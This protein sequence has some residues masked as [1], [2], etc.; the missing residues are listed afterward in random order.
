MIV[1]RILKKFQQILN[2]HQKI[3]IIELTILMVI[4]GFMEMLSVSL[5]VPFI[6]AVMDPGA[7]MEKWYA[8]IFCNIF[9]IGQGETRKF[10]IVLAVVLALLYVIKNLYL[11]LE[12]NFQYRFVY[13]NMF[14]I[15]QRLLNNYLHRPYEYFLAIETGEVIRVI[16]TDVTNS[17]LA[18]TSLL[19]IFAEV[20]VT[21]VLLV[22]LLVISTFITIGIIVILCAAL[23]IIMCV[24]KPIMAKAGK[25]NQRAAA[26][27]NKWMMQSIQGIKEIKISQK[28]SYFEKEFAANGQSYVNTLRINAVLSQLPRF[29]IE[30]VS[31]SA[32][33]IMIAV[34]IGNGTDLVTFIPTLSALAMAAVR[35]L[36][37][38]NRISSGLGLLAYYEPSIDKLIKNLNEAQLAPLDI[39]D[40]RVAIKPLQ[41]N[42]SLSH[43]YF[44]YPSNDDKYVLKDSSLII[45][46]GESI[47]ITGPSGAGKTTAIDI[48]IGLLKPQKGVV[49]ID[50]TDI[51][52]DR[53]DWFK[54]IGYI[55]QSIFML[56]GSIRDNVAFGILKEE[57]VDDQIWTALK[58]ASL[59]D[60]VKSLPDQL[61]TKVGE[62]GVRISGGQKQRIGI[63][64][65]LYNNPSILIFDEATSALD[66]DTEKA[67]M[68][69]VE[70]LHGQ[71]TMVIIAHRLTTIENCDH[72]FQVKDSNIIRIR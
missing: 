48:L 72:V 65:A 40:K 41:D 45:H 10:L 71:K 47:G 61:D 22:T 57:V 54:Q 18:L 43:I 27:I 68:Q 12:N 39:Y 9:H 20:I 69:S 55:P 3:R 17:F 38:I 21:G 7:T 46:K 31:M 11:L 53:E 23:L 6:N 49:T 59:Y 14:M 44:H 16:Q 52:L 67:I 62:R 19:E 2:R 51:M 8:K 37:A 32:I 58:E 34:M 24:V 30:A 60:F 28:E 29:I 13:G 25:K 42:V 70:N 26:E 1:H 66:N 33:F 36:P 63:A 4:G 15:Q 64:R 56:D 35:L 50:G 5:M